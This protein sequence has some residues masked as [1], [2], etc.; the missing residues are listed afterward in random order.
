VIA[1]CGGLWALPT[2][3]ETVEAIRKAA[4]G[5]SNK[6][7]MNRGTINDA[8]DTCIVFR[9]SVDYTMEISITVT[10]LEDLN[11]YSDE[12][13]G[14][15]NLTWEQP[16]GTFAA[17]KPEQHDS[18]MEFDSTLG[19]PGEGPEIFSMRRIVDTFPAQID[20]DK[21]RICCLE[22]CKVVGHYHQ[23]KPSKK[24]PADEKKKP[25]T[26]AALRTKRKGK[27]CTKHAIGTEC[28]RDHC[29]CKAQLE[30]GDPTRFLN[31]VH[32]SIHDDEEDNLILQQQ[33]E[34][35]ALFNQSED[36]EED[37]LEE[38][39]PSKTET[40]WKKKE[41]KDS[42]PVQWTQVTVKLP[43][44]IAT[45][46]PT[47]QSS[48]SSVTSHSFS[49]S[50][51]STTT[52]SSS[53]SS[54]S[55][56]D[57]L[58]PSQGP[59]TFCVEN[60]T[61]VKYK[62]CDPD[63]A[64]CIKALLGMQHPLA[65]CVLEWIHR[66]DDYYEFFY[67]NKK[68]QL[69]WY[70]ERFLDDGYLYYSQDGSLLRTPQGN[71]E[72]HAAMKRLPDLLKDY[73]HKDPSPP[74]I[75]TPI[76]PEQKQEDEKKDEQE[77]EKKYEDEDEY[78][79]EDVVPPGPIPPIPVPPA[80]IPPAPVCVFQHAPVAPIPAA[81]V[82]QP[83]QWRGLLAGRI[84][85]YPVPR[86]NCQHLCDAD[87]IAPQHLVI[88]RFDATV[89]GVMIFQEGGVNEKEW[90][91][92]CWHSFW[93]IFLK[94]S[95]EYTYPNT[96]GLEGVI[97]VGS[98]TRDATEEITRMGWTRRGRYN[99]VNHLLCKAGLT[100]YRLAKVYSRFA[101]LLR[102][103]A[104]LMKM[105]AVTGDGKINSRYLNALIHKAV[106][107]KKM[108]KHLRRRPQVFVDTICYVF[109]Q[110]VSERLHLLAVVGT[111]KEPRPELF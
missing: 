31:G 14:E 32:N 28:E 12:E 93:S 43:K 82:L 40:K 65:H 21:K 87:D 46:T 33:D 26:G 107:Y 63:P 49:S 34:W 81:V 19:Y 23:I 67:G 2:K 66:D 56:S 35:T 90:W 45:N 72:E 20:W 53:S 50:S 3:K 58:I 95:T 89:K 55:T 98:R 30:V 79:E 64:F 39:P 37:K 7:N 38:P 94:T 75:E 24:K 78:E 47:S 69:K 5:K 77:D 13:E 36:E 57:T 27:L 62:D 17:Q 91:N 109:N 48:T 41:K 16:D 88:D 11:E 99:R 44:A 83:A 100:Q 104:E 108:V 80:I 106:S 111:K 10:N 29:H 8:N 68:K 96:Q 105:H 92:G 74:D 84:R 102:G 60:K 103:Q 97:P 42:S 52:S 110:A 4:E 76:A 15:F 25:L 22:E 61:E 86:V 85:V 71:R 54:S 18:V 6:T 51:S 9:C 73:E 70:D 59:P 1:E 101:L